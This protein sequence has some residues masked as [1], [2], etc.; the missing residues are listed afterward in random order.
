MKKEE[1]TYDEM[2]FMYQFLSH[3]KTDADI[4]ETRVQMIKIY[5]NLISKYG[6]VKAMR[7]MV[8]ST[9]KDFFYGK[10]KYLSDAILESWLYPVLK[11]HLGLIKPTKIQ[12]NETVTP[13]I[14]AICGKEIKGKVHFDHKWPYS[15]FFDYLGDDNIFATCKECNIA[16]KDSPPKPDY[17]K[18]CKH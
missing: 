11:T 6:H 17:G 14:C 7:K 8:L 4:L 12:T 18:V 10:S 3:F 5:D 16:K 1:L 15:L 9:Y 2:I 13:R